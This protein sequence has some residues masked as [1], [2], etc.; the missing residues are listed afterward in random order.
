MAVAAQLQKLAEKIRRGQL[1]MFDGSDLPSFWK[2][3]GM[4]G[5]LHDR[6]PFLGN[7]MR[8]QGKQ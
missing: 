5:P 8:E 1:T 2:G 3:P 7:K 4:K 6:Y